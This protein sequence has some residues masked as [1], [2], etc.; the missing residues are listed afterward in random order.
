MPLFSKQKNPDTFPYAFK[1]AL[2]AVGEHI[3]AVKPTEESARLEQRRF[4]GFKAA[5]RFH[6]LHTLNLGLEQFHT[7][8]KVR[9]GVNEYWL[10]TVTTSWK[11]LTE[12]TYD[13][14]S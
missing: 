3:I 12:G 5:V 8:V 2:E 4:S 13:E 7:R 9:Q 6:P 1:H 11:L 10:T 14:V